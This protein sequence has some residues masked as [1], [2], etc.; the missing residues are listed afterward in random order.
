MWICKTHEYRILQKFTI[1]MQCCF[2]G[3]EASISGENVAEDCQHVA[4]PV[5]HFTNMPAPFLN[6]M[7]TLKW[8]P[9]TAK[10]LHKLTSTPKYRTQQSPNNL[11]F[12]RS[13]FLRILS[14]FCWLETKTNERLLSKSHWEMRT[15]KELLPMLAKP[16]ADKSADSRRVWGRFLKIWLKSFAL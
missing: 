7:S 12:K 14:T 3:E 2:H 10:Q 6:S 9:E 8:P 1:W 16:P 5:S 11:C 4:Q 13:V 15:N